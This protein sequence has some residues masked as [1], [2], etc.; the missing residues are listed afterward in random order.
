MD[1]MASRAEQSREQLHGPLPSDIIGGGSA[2]CTQPYSTALD[3]FK[4]AA[5]LR[6]ARAK[7]RPRSQNCVRTPRVPFMRTVC[8]LFLSLSL[9]R[10]ASTRNG[11]LLAH[12]S[13][14]LGR[15]NYFCRTKQ[16][17]LSRPFFFSPSLLCPR[18]PAERLFSRLSRHST[19]RHVS[20]RVQGVASRFSPLLSSS[21]LFSA[22]VFCLFQPMSSEDG[23]FVTLGSPRPRPAE[24]IARPIEQSPHTCLC[25]HLAHSEPRS[26]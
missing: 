25:L 5:Y 21:L 19:R 3:P 24:L 6:L 18:R 26:R 1:V 17:L 7:N 20:S 12:S 22:V 4:K 13:I 23:R 9:D 2:R 15:P 16:A 8:S 11:P 10:I 14:D